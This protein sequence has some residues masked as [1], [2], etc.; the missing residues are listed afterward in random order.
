MGGEQ[1]AVRLGRGVLLLGLGP[2]TYDPPPLPAL[3]TGW[4]FM[5]NA[6]VEEVENAWN[7]YYTSAGLE[8]T[9]EACCGLGPLKATVGC[10]SKEMACAAPERHLWW[11]LYSPTEAVD[12]LVANWSWWVIIVT[13]GGGRDN[14]LRLRRRDDDEHLQP[15]VA[16]A[17]GG[18]WVAAGG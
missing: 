11:D 10:L 14:C 9:R 7:L 15:H 8:E 16:A 6:C 18:I 4:P 17:A 5:K 12:A 1:P 13:A 2:P 3:S